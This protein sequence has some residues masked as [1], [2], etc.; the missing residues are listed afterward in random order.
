MRSLSVALFAALLLAFAPTVQAQM[1]AI[2]NR[3]AAAYPVRFNV[4]VRTDA[5][6]VT[7]A[8]PDLSLLTAVQSDDALERLSLDGDARGSRLLARFRF[9]SLEAFNAWYARPA[10]QAMITRL[11]EAAPQENG[12][13]Y[14]LDVQRGGQ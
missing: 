13:S 14:E 5:S 2:A 11:R 12:F 6:D 1:T 10:T 3:D 4:G 7:A 8:L 9:P